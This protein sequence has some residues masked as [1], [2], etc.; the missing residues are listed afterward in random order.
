[1][2]APLVS[3]LLSNPV[4]GSGVR[5]GEALAPQPAISIVVYG[6]PAPQGSKR[7]VGRGV[8][9]ESSTKVKPWRQDVVA[10]AQEAIFSCEMTNDVLW[11]PLDGPLAVRMVFS[12]RKP[13]SAPKR[14][15][16]WPDRIPDLSKLI[17]STED[18]LTTAG[19]WRDDARVVD[20]DRAAKVFVGE[21]PE[22]LMS[23]GC[24]IEIRQVT[25]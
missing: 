20:Y 16:T 6:E 4:A 7:H 17:R 22:A 10:A 19:V 13:Q 18:A 25:S 2:T 5:E 12:M 11:E 15:Q 8:M 21:D 14:R 1:M 23:T 9:V 24:R 3:G